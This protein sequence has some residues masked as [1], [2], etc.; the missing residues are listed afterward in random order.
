MRNLVIRLLGLMLFP[1][2]S[3]LPALAQDGAA[4]Q[5]KIW[6]QVEAAPA[7]G[8]FY[9]I[10]SGTNV[11]HVFGTIHV[12]TAE[13][14]PLSLP[15]TRALIDAK[16]L[17]VEANILDQASVVRHVTEHAIYAPPSSLEQHAPPA[18]MQKLLPALERYQFPRQQAMAMKPWM[19]ALTLSVL[20]AARAG[21]DPNWGADA[22]L[23]GFAASQKKPIV[24]IEGLARQFEIFSGL[25]HERQLLFLEE[26]LQELARGD[27][28]ERLTKLV[29]AWANADAAGLESEWK[30][31]QQSDFASHKFTLDTLLTQRNRDM[32]SRIDEYLRSG[33]TYFVAIGAL[34]LVGDDSVIE[35]LKK[36]GHRVRRL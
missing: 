13:F 28:S 24:E 1:L 4:A 16:F 2:W 30:Y 20:E 19:L 31:L 6:R 11:V 35:L 27:A 33:E 15:V 7:R 36:R 32:A 12:G 29:Q 14:Y 18:L 9:E 8:L 23:L 34:H 10:K 5:Q 25:D 22:Y 17:A 3:P 26:T 21:Y